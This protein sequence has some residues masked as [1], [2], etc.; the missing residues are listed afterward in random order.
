MYTDASKLEGIQLKFV[1]QCQNHF[2]TY[3]HATY[4]DLLK[5]IK[6]MFRTTEEFILMHYIL[7]LFNRV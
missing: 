4:E 7:F 3:G 2:F 6:C 1:A 5:F